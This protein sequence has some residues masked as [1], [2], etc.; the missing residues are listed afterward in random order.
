MILGS[1]LMLQIFEMESS[2][3]KITLGRFNSNAVELSASFTFT[4]T[5]NVL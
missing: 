3:S 4:L 1:F 5:R 2:L